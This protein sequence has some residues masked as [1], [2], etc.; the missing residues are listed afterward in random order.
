MG[1]RYY[2]YDRNNNLIEKEFIKSDNSK[3]SDNSKTIYEYNQ[4][5]QKI[6]EIDF[7]LPTSD[8]KKYVFSQSVERRY[9]GQGK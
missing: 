9:N 7:D 1:T 2:T 6:K 4:K 5:N 8:K 3:Y